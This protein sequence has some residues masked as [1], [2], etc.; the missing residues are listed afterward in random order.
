VKTFLTSGNAPIR[1]V[2]ARDKRGKNN[3]ARASINNHNNNTHNKNKKPT[4]P[5]QQTDQQQNAT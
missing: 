5:N 2:P 1:A 3:D 4:S